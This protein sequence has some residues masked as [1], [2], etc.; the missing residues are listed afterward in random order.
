VGDDSFDY[1]HNA[2]SGA[3]MGAVVCMRCNKHHGYCVEVQQQLTG[4]YDDGGGD[5]KEN[6]N[7]IPRTQQSN[8]GGK[9]GGRRKGAGLRYLSAEMLSTS[10]QLASIIDARVQEDKFRAGNTCVVVKL[11]FKG[12]HIL[13]TLRPGNPCLDTLGDAYGDEES[14]WKSRELEL[15]IEEDSFDG[16]QWIRCEAVAAAPGK[17]SKG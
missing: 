12:E 7:M 9:G 4:V 16:K 13:W 10:H 14:T 1:G 3:C 2:A 5:N 6:N 8:T 17:K 15:F 11:K